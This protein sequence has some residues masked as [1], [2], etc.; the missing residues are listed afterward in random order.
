[1]LNRQINFK[2]VSFFALLF[3]LDLV[4]TPL[5]SAQSNYVETIPGAGVS[6]EMIFVK[7]GTSNMGLSPD[8]ELYEPAEGPTTKAKVT[9]FWMG[10]Y[11]VTYDEYVIFQYKAKDTETSNLKASDFQVDAISRP[12]PPY[13]DMAFGMGTVGGFPAVSMTQQAA[14][15]YCQWLYLKTG[16]FYRLPTE[17]EWEYAC[18]AGQQD[19]QPAELET[20]AWYFDNSFEKFQK[21]GQKAANAWG[22]HDMLGNVAEWTL[23][24]YV[25]DYHEQFPEPT[26]GVWVKPELKY[27]HTTRGGS[28][29]DDA[30]DCHCAARLKSTPLW[31]RRDPQ[32]PKSKWWNTNAAFVGF[33]LVRPEHQPSHA[34]IIA[35][36]EEAIRD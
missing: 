5:A 30:A 25:E 17:A 22:F 8:D 35:F 19:A 26:A 4:F 12:T 14:L 34:E 33:R 13:E 20:A 10:K 2:N 24:K 16:N 15:R 11:E 32:I 7:G 1:M 28:F 36:F 18:R 9:N 29:D 27:P 3:L 21:V 23:D 6:F 31:Q